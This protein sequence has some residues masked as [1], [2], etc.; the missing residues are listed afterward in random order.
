MPPA[1]ITSCEEL[2]CMFTRKMVLMAYICTTWSSVFYDDVLL[3]TGQRNQA[4][5]F[6]YFF[7]TFFS[8]VQPSTGASIPLIS[9]VYL[10]VKVGRI[11]CCND[12]VGH[13]IGT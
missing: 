7:A 10:R 5:I 11:G 8:S 3:S 13:T 9:T 4:Q 12:N 2:K 1:T 6:A